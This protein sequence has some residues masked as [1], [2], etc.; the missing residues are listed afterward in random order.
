MD[1]ALLQAQA[2]NEILMREIHHR[3]KN[4]LQLILS[5]IHIHSRSAAGELRPIF[6]DLQ[7]RVYA[8]ARVYERIHTTAA[9]EE[10][11]VCGL[12]QEICSD[13]GAGAPEGARVQVTAGEPVVLGNDAAIAVALIT[14]EFGWVD[15]VR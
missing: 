1:E 3:V 5:L 12:L 10:L 11:E 6:I 13:L 8:T 15:I 7:R 4:S 9:M 2:R 14:N